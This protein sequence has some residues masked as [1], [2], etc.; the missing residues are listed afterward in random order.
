LL[1]CCTCVTH[2]KDTH[3]FLVDE[4]HSTSEARTHRW[5]TRRTH[6]GDVHVFISKSVIALAI[7]VIHDA[8]VHSIVIVTA[9]WCCTRRWVVDGSDLDGTVEI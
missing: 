4:A 6:S 7:V 9:V 1:N 8:V 2:S 5:P 3:V